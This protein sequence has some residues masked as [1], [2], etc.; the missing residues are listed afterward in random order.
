MSSLEASSLWQ[1]IL[2]Y[3]DLTLSQ[4]LNY[5]ESILAKFSMNIQQA[6]HTV[7]CMRNGVDSFFYR[8]TLASAHLFTL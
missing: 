6:L 7:F 4:W 5:I 2:R 3:I 1:T 8:Y